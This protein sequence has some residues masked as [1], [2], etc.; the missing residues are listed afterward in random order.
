MKIIRLKKRGNIAG[1]AKHLAKKYGPADEGY[2]TRCMA[3]EEVANYPV[4]TRKSVCARAH[5]EA[6]GIW[7]AESKKKKKVEKFLKQLRKISN[8]YE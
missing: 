2:F 4:E 3:A 8:S 1:L 5:K 7:P 6:I